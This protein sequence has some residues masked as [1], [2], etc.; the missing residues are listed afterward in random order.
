[1]EFVWRTRPNIHKA[2]FLSW[3]LKHH[4]DSTRMIRWHACRLKNLSYVLRRP[5]TSSAHSRR[6]AP[7]LKS[8]L[9]STYSGTPHVLCHLGSSL[10]LSY[11]KLRHSAVWQKLHSQDYALLGCD[12][13]YISTNVS[14]NPSTNYF[15][16]SHCI[17]RA[18]SYIPNMKVESS[19][20]KFVP[21]YQNIRRH[22]TES[23]NPRTHNRE[24]LMSE[25][26]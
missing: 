17:F 6:G 14:D 5:Q 19:T 12:F 7:I 22:T 10:T 26:P 1:M 21:V 8:C 24:N 3:F 4:V 16:Q 23:H 11:T 9:S 20:E 2:V 25:V 13:M 18:N 15:G